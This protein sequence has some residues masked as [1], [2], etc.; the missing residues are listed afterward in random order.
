MRRLGYDPT[1][2]G[3]T[4]QAVDPRTV[5]A[6]SPWL[7]TYEGI[8]PGFTVGLWLPENPEPWL[9]WLRQRGVATPEDFWDIYRPA[10]E[11]R[12]PPD[13]CAAAL[14]RRGDR[15][16]LPHRR[17]PRLARRAA[18]ERAVVRPHLLSP[19]ASALHRAGALQRALR[20]RPAA[21]LSGARPSPRCRARPAPD[22]RLLAGPGR[23]GRSLRHWRRQ[24]RRDWTDDDF[25]TVRAVYWGMISEV[26]LQIGRLLD[27][28]A[29]AGSLRRHRRRAHLG[30]RRDAGRPLGARQVRLFRTVLSRAARHPRSA[31]QSAAGG[32]DAFTESIDIMPTLIDLAGGRP[33]RHIDGRSLRPLLDGGRPVR[34]A[35]RGSLGIRLP[36][37]RDR[38]RPAGARSRP[39]HLLARRP[40][41]PRA[42]NTSTS[43][44]CGR[45][46]SISTTT[47]TNSPTAP[48][49]APTCRPARLRRE[50]SRLARPPSRPHADR[51]RAHAQRARR[52]AAVA[53]PEPLHQPLIPAKART[54]SSALHSFRKDRDQQVHIGEAVWRGCLR[55]VI[56]DGGDGVGDVA[57]GSQRGSRGVGNLG[58]AEVL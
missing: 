12:R 1:L 38:R 58:E 8:L 33:P 15:D 24:Y 56:A 32:V 4:D 19:P 51:H 27:G 53:S 47:P 10:G 2:F 43:P 54:Q 7:R 18:E 55:G 40:P 22:H 41:R 37:G 57:F 49:T 26:D 9:A 21:R 30:S 3:Y 16:G 25:R 6:D 50:A 14:R 48:A 52:R 5:A 36:R 23:R 13:Q 29:A 35:R 42:S 34:L 46:S 11:A 28:L 45:S 17:L 39:R 20:S 44:G 31:R